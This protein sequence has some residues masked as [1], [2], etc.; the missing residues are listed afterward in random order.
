MYLQK[1]GQNIFANPANL[2]GLGSIYPFYVRA[3]IT[4]VKGHLRPQLQI[5]VYRYLVV[6]GQGL[7]MVTV[8]NDLQQARGITSL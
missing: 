4:P 3:A 2:Y 8:D 7:K 5:H 6:Q 1:P